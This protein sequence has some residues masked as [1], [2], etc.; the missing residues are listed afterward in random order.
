MKTIL[1]VVFGIAPSVLIVGF[2]IQWLFP[3]FAKFSA[4]TKTI[5]RVVGIMSV[6]GLLVLGYLDYRNR[7]LQALYGRVVSP[8]TGSQDAVSAVRKIATYRGRRATEIL[9]AVATS[10]SGWSEAT[11]TRTAAIEELEKR[12]DPE[13][14]ATLADLLQPHESLRTRE[15]ASAALERLPCTAECDAHILHYLERVWRGEPNYEDRLNGG[16]ETRAFIHKA[17][18]TVYERLIIVLRREKI[19]TLKNLA[20]IYGLGSDNPSLFALQIV[21]RAKLVE[22]CPY[23]L[24]SA[25]G[26]KTYSPSDYKAPIA[27]VQA[28]VTELKC[29]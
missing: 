14:G 11:G 7:H 16:E 19:S 28:A 18:E 27:E 10:G 21:V 9:L 25:N 4:T 15:M 29:Q 20:Q 26:L 23:L 13:V 2:I 8:L 24:R 17:Q 1:G 6:I 22:A 12:D 5:L 3:G